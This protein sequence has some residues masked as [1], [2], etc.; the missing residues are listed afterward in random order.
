MKSVS[1]FANTTK[2]ASK[3]TRQ[4]VAAASKVRRQ[5]HEGAP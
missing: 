3:A 5:D 1:A 4:V 2:V